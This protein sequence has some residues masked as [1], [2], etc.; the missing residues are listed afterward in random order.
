[1]KDLQ[2][3]NGVIKE[4]PRLFLVGF[5]APDRAPNM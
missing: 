4:T 1:M 2:Y 5:I 3:T